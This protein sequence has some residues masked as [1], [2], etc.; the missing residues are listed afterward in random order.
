[1]PKNSKK[2]SY[3]WCIL[4]KINSLLRNL[5][6]FDPTFRLPTCTSLGQK[7][8]WRSILFSYTYVF[9]GQAWA[10]LNEGKFFLNS[11]ATIKVL[12]YL[13]G[14]ESASI[15]ISLFR[16]H[17]IKFLELSKSCFK[18][19][20]FGRTFFTIVDLGLKAL[21]GGIYLM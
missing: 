14:L 1:M 16:P 19:F 2:K 20:P 8:F 4:F 10:N 12:T 21:K 11:G 17:F 15:G 6:F 7:P 5:F 18:M 13:E 3:Q 9:T